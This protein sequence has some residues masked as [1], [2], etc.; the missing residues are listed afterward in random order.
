VT[1]TSPVVVVRR[2]LPAPPEAV[3]DEWLDPQAML[4]WMC[5]R[6]ARCLGVTMDPRVGGGL[7]IDIEDEG[8]EFFV[9]GVF[10]VLDRP[11]LLRF[12][13]SCS[14]WADPGL[15]TTV[16]VTLDPQDGDRTLMTIRHVL[17]PADLAGRHAH[18]WQTIA[19]QLATELTAELAPEL[20]AEPRPTDEGRR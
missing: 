8:A 15:R 17:L 10:L 1:D 19:D 7:R 14:I 2:T 4:D 18:G 12:T 13:W 16:T 6:P 5:P 9:S 20:T 3:Y 11:H